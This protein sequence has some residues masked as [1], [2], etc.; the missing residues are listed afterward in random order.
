MVGVTTW[1]R[2]CRRHISNGYHESF[3]DPAETRARARSNWTLLGRTRRAEHRPKEVYVYVLEPEHASACAKRR[4]SQGRLR[5]MRGSG[6]SSPL[7]DR[8]LTRRLVQAF[9]SVA[10]E[11][12]AAAKGY[13]RLS[14]RPRTAR[15]RP[16]TSSPLTASVLRRMQA[17]DTVLCVQDGTDL[18]FTTH[19]RCNRYQPDR[20][21]GTRTAPLDLRRERRG[22]AARGGARAVRRARARR[23]CPQRKSWRRG[24]AR[25]RRC[26]P[27]EWSA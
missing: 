12:W 19:A 23:G 9:C 20:G 6:T 4:R 25:L 13:Y 3:V 22:A 5:C 14:T 2:G 16:R 8:R 18:N 24:V 17:Q 10:R 11:D 21:T 7:G 1:P 26:C 27:R 15:S